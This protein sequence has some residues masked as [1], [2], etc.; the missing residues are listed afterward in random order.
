M[1]H[2]I[3]VRPTHPDHRPNM[4]AD[5][6][7]VCVQVLQDGVEPLQRKAYLYAS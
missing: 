1:A 4:R 3:A 5:V 6:Q 7:N 2:S